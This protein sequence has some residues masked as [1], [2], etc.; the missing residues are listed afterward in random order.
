MK[1]NFI[2]EIFYYK[3]YFFEFFNELNEDVQKKFNWTLELIE[4][5]DL[6]PKKYFQHMTG[7]VG[8]YEIRVEVG[9]NI[10]SPESFRDR[11]F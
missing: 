7:T 8:L 6:V 4:K 3:H 11:F 1:E 2:R 9:S 5:I 10:F